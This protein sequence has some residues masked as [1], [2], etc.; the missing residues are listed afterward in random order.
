MLAALMVAGCAT[1]PSMPAAPGT[2]QCG[3]AT[4]AAIG[5]E[6]IMGVG[7]DGFISDSNLV[8]STSVSPGSASCTRV[9]GT[10]PIVR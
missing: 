3:P 8:F 5:G 6:A 2:V 9:G 1:P 4:S 7:S 10:V